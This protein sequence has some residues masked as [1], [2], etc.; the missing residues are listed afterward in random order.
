MSGWWQRRA[1]RTIHEFRT[2]L[3]RYK[4]QERRIARAAL[5][6]DP[7]ITAAVYAH[8]AEH[9]LSEQ[10]V[11]KR[12]RTY[13]D[14]IIPHFNVLSYYKV[15]YNAAKILLN[16]L[17]KVSVDHQDERRSGIARGGCCGCG[18]W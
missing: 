7:A 6:T 4:L 8:M 15:G 10:A 11:R 14:E 13:L 12:V 18:D 5:A 1:L 3:A 9:G 17:Y 2:R 16:L